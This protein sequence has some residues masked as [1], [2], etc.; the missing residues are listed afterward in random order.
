[1]AGFDD[2]VEDIKKAIV[3]MKSLEIT[4]AVGPI[5]WDVAKQDYVPT[6]DATVKAMKTKI[7]LF[8]GDIT[9]Q[10]D[11]DFATG[12]LQSVRDYHLKTQGDGNDI[13]KK[14]V[15]ALEGLFELALRLKKDA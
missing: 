8:G 14:N 6:T 2:F 7:D 12:G 9:T 3:N 4:T 1:M 11:P 10:M 15:E 5:S 13:I